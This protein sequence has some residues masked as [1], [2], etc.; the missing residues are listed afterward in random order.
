M[1]RSERLLE[2]LQILYKYRRPVTGKILASQLGISLRTLYRDIATLQQQGAM[3]TGEAG[4]GYL[5]QP[6]F[7]LPPLMFKTEEIEALLIGCRWVVNQTDSQLTEAA[8]QAIAKLCAILPKHQQETLNS[9]LLIGYPKLIEP[10]DQEV[11]TIRKAINQN[12]KIIIEYSDMHQKA[13][14]RLI[15]P[16]AIGFFHHTLVICGWCELREAFRHFR[17]DRI[18]NLTLQNETFPRKQKELLEAWHHFQKIPKPLF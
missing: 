6:G 13:T 9:S 7:T 18:K 17:I 8:Q 5:L 14:K 11:I 15:W 4:S 12:L 1:T 2:L 16:F 3:I 10:Y